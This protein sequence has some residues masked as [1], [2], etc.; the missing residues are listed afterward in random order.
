MTTPSVAPG[1]V[2]LIFPLGQKCAR[3]IDMSTRDM[4]NAHK[5]CSILLYDKM[6]TLANGK[7][8]QNLT[9]AEVN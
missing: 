4:S 8:T 7:Q 5:G 6:T 3:K 9:S 1:L 2:L